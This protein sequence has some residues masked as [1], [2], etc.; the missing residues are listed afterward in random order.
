MLRRS[1]RNFSV[2]GFSFGEMILI[3]L[4]TL[5]VVGP[6]RL[7]Q[8]LKTMGAWA[9]KLRKMTMD[10]RQ[11]TGID[12]M[13]RAEGIQ[14]SELRTLMRGYHGGPPA[15][16]PA[17]PARPYDDPYANL[18]ADPL[19]EYP[20]EGADAYGALPDAL[21]AAAAPVAAVAPAPPPVSSAGCATVA[22]KS[23]SRKIGPTSIGA[24]CN[25]TNIPRPF[26]VFTIS[27]Q[28]TAPSIACVAHDS[29]TPAYASARC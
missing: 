17:S 21:L 1:H 8:M 7:P 16:A 26:V 23:F 20:P 18:D 12:E 4:V 15:S 3:M 27:S 19:R 25:R 5:V 29:T 24:A 28:Y 6:Q 9:R 13:L 10:V 14:L 22:L 2:F 11:Q